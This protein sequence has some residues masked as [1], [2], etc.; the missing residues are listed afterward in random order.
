MY[1]TVLHDE[2]RDLCAKATGFAQDWPAA[3]AEEMSE[4]AFWYANIWGSSPQFYQHTEHDATG[5]W[6]G[7][8]GNAYWWKG[9]DQ[10]LVVRIDGDWHTD[11]RGHL[12]YVPGAVRYFRVRPCQHDYETKTLGRC[13]RRLTCRRCGLSFEED[14]SD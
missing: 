11:A 14:S 3:I 6:R 4:G 9:R 13:W 12:A 10:W 7:F 1:D 5:Q 2:I 8:A